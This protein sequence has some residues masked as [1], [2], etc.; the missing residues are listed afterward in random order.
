MSTDAQPMAKL[1]TPQAIAGFVAEVREHCGVDY[2]QYA[3]A[4]LG[5]RVSRQMRAEGLDDIAAYGNA[6]CADS[7]CLG[8]LMLALSSHVTSLFRHPGFF[9]VLRETVVPMLRTYP[10]VNVW[11]AGCS[12]GEHAYATAIVLQEEGL[13]AKSRIYATDAADVALARAKEGVYSMDALREVDYLDAGGTSSLAR[14]LTVHGDHAALAASLRDRITFAQH[15]LATDASFNEFQLIVCRDVMIYFD[16]KLQAR[17]FDVMHQ[18]LCRFG[19]LGVG[20]GESI[21]LHPRSAC[22]EAL[23]AA[24]K[25][26]RRME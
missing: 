14:Y 21:R 26:Y 23:D 3:P 17:A 15:N 13:G 22:Y 18:S 16:A 8:R 9:R 6:V 10:S 4:S 5:R 12:T 24:E 20:R 11:C 25:L 19:V 1:P 2:A 7:A